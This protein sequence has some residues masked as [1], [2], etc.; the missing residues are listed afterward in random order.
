M[1]AA[2]AQGPSALAFPW[3]SLEQLPRATARSWGALQRRLANDSVAHRLAQALEGWLGEPVC[4]K[5][6]K[7]RAMPMQPD[8]PSTRLRFRLGAG[9]GEVIVCIDTRLATRLVNHALNRKAAL[10]DPLSSIEPSLLGAVAAVFAKIIDDARFDFDWAFA[11][12]PLELSD[13]HRAQLDAT[14][15]IGPSAYPV[16]V[17]FV[18]NWLLPPEPAVHLSALG[19]LELG[20]PL[21]I[22]QSLIMREDLARIAPGAA[23]VTGAG[24]WV[25]ESRVGHGVLVAPLGERGIFVQLQPEGK[26]VL[27]EGSVTLNHDDSKSEIQSEHSSD[28]LVDTLFEAPVVVRVELGS[29]SL[30]ARQWALLRPGD[31]VETSQCLGTEVTLRVAGQ[32]LAKGELLNVDGELGVRITKLLVGSDS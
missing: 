21:V 20:L 26:I 25:D 32:A 15:Q 23:F 13:A 4:I 16:A 18:I 2:V 12:D 14:L 27:G 3:G 7:L 6:Q 17:G 1:I 11:L 24:L 9:A 31:I 8:G 10:S 28:A 19:P 5:R 29:V 30:P 22:G